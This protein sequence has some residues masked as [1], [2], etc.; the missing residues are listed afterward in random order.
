MYQFLG[1]TLTTFYQSSK[2]DK[3]WQLGYSPYQIWIYEIILQQ[4]RMAQGM[5]YFDKFIKRFPNIETLAKSSL[6]EVL[7]QWQGLGYYSRARNLHA[8]AR[9]IS[10]NLNNEFPKTY[11]A[12]IKLKGIGKYTAAAISSFAY[13]ENQ[14]VLDGN[15]YRVLSRYFGETTEINSSQAP[16]TF[17]A[18]LEKIHKNFDS[19]ILNQSL[20]DY[21]AQICTAKLP[22]CSE[23]KLNLHCVA[24][25]S[26]Q[27]I[28]YPQKIKPNKLRNR[29]FYCVFYLNEDVIYLKKRIEKDIWQDLYQGDMVESEAFPDKRFIF[30]IKEKDFDLDWS[31]QRLTHQKI[32]IKFAIKPIESFDLNTLGEENFY[33]LSELHRIPMPKIIDTFLRNL[34]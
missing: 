14:Y 27:I 30:P 11:D 23:C 7:E 17:Y 4:T 3:P 33:A 25:L 21:G 10:E 13:G 12:L 8:T 15:V 18:Y 34:R 19:Q 22:K 31:I 6:D 2:Q 29:Y 26:N 5:P 16:K 20:M 24:Y 28:H 32:H 1:E 9:F